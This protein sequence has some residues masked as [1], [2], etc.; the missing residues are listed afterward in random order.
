MAALILAGGEK[1]ERSAYSNSEI[2]LTQVSRDRTFGQASDIELETTHLLEIKQRVNDLL[3]KITQTD[4]AQI[5]NH[6]ERKHWLFAA[7]AKEY[8]LIDNII[9]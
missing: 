4:S 6:M 1:G 5:H 2:M 8:G 3:A 7:Q 9:E